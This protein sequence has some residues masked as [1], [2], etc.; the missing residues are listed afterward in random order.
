MAGALLLLML[1]VL[2]IGPACRLAQNQTVSWD[3]VNRIYTPLNLVAKFGPV[4]RMLQRYIRDVWR[5]K[6]PRVKPS[7]P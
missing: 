1:Y 4:D 7:S 3:F 6:A 5:V 2:S